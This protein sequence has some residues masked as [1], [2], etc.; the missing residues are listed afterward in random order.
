M[1]KLQ[2]P[3]DPIGLGS[4]LDVYF[5]DVHEGGIDWYQ[6]TEKA[7]APPF[8]GEMWIGG[9][10]LFGHFNGPKKK[11]AI[12]TNGTQVLKVE[13]SYIVTLT[14][15]DKHEADPALRKL[16]LEQIGERLF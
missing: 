4:L 3:F 13:H 6:P 10:V 15:K 14:D 2:K 12:M 5:L 16:V 9:S 11:I 1:G 7:V 8:R